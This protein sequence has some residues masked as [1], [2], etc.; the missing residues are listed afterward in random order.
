MVTVAL[1]VNPQGFKHGVRL[2]NAMPTFRLQ[3][4]T[5]RSH[6]PDA[7]L[8]K[9]TQKKGSRKSGPKPQSSHAKPASNPTNA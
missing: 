9:D 2:T 5:L 7:K 1:Q 3:V 8:Q 6:T 4:S